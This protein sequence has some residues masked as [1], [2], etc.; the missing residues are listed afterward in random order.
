MPVP[1]K[2]LLIDDDPSLVVLLGRWFEEFR[3]GPFALEHAADFDGGLRRLMSGSYALC[4]LDDR[5]GMR[6]GLELLSEAKTKNCPT[7]VILLM[8]EGREDADMTAIDAGAADFLGKCELTPRL[9]ERAVRYAL[10]M[11]DTLAQLRQLAT[12]DELT[13][14][15]NRREFERI[16]REEWERSTRFARAFSLVMV[17]IDHFKLVNDTHGHQVGDAVLRHVASLLAG[18]VRLV[19]RVARYGG[20]E[21]ALIMIETDRKS[22]HTAAERLRSLLEET[23][24]ILPG[25]QLTI[26]VTISAGVAACPEDADSVETLVAAADAALYTAKRLGRNRVLTAKSRMTQAPWQTTRA[27]LLPSA[28]P[29][30]RVDPPVKGG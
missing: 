11:S 9:L 1:R 4:L 15:L 3:S 29:A 17:D 30:K 6:D 22:A 18:Q 5:L 8:G 12:H 26:A 13:T 7:P 14:V 28:N 20:E 24:C 16:I 10:K 25:K 27:S 2:I 19:D 21:F 23:P